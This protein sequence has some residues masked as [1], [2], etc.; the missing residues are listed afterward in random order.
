GDVFAV[1]WTD[2]KMHPYND[3]RCTW[4]ARFHLID[5]RLQIRA[6]LFNRN[7]VES[8]VDSKLE[9]EDIDRIHQVRRETAQ[10]AFSGASAGAG[11][12]HAKIRTDRAQLLH[13]EHRPG[14]A[15]ADGKAF[16]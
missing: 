12:D 2:H 5:H 8:I 13:Q 11:I 9:N 7:A 16:R 6:R 10:P 3:H 14:L 15:R 1:R 4:I